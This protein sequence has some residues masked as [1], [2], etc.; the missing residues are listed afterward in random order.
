MSNLI[1]LGYYDDAMSGDMDEDGGDGALGF[2]EMGA[3]PLA[4]FR[5]GR[6]PQRARVARP[7]LPV[8]GSQIA[9]YNRLLQTPRGGVGTR[10]PGIR[11]TVAG[12]AV[13]TMSTAGA[14]NTAQAVITPYKRMK[15]TRL[16]VGYAATGTPGVLVLATTAFVSDRNQFGNATGIDIN[17]AFASNATFA[18]INWDVIDPQTPLQINL[19]TSGN[20][21]AAST[22]TQ[23][24]V[25]F[26]IAH[27]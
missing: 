6:R 2:D 15:P 26:G 25:L 4:L 19:Q 23:S 10:E 12:S 16:I 20:L 18:A 21:G 5:R 9:A 8:V 14:V 11:E 3:S 1:E 22:I 13:V 17:A 24:F 7:G 27:N